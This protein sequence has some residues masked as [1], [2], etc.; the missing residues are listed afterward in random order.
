MNADGTGLRR[1]TG[2]TIWEEDPT[3][4]PDGR[5]I[6]FAG[7]PPRGSRRDIYVV[8]ADGSGLRKLLLSDSDNREPEWSPDG[9]RITFSSLR[10]DDQ[11][12]VVEDQRIWVMQADGTGATPLVPGF[13]PSWSP[14][15]RRLVF[16]RGISGPGG[17]ET[18]LFLVGSDGSGEVQLTNP[19][20]SAHADLYPEWSPTGDYIAFTRIKYATPIV[21]NLW[22]IRPD[23]TGLQ[24]VGGPQLAAYQP[25]WSPDGTEIVFADGTDGQLKVISL[26]SPASIRS[27]AAFPAAVNESPSWGPEQ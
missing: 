4:S 11:G 14:D 19:Q 15:S 5:R 6:A 24:Q 16:D 21:A 26:E 25:S 12:M 27:F 9:S 18:G 3:W 22:V 1:V 10:V 8:D 7:T 20:P 2:D 13:A 17:V 23:G